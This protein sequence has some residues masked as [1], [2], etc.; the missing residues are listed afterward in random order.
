MSDSAV[1]L[2]RVFALPENGAGD[3]SPDRWNTFQATLSREVKTIKWPA[4]MPDVAE[5]IG[6][7][8]DVKLP[9][10]FL[11]SWKRTVELRRLLSESRT[12]PE[13]TKYF[14]LADHTIR[15][16]HHPYIEVKIRNVPVK[17]IE[18]TVSLACKLK[19]FVLRIKAGEIEEIRTGRCE[20]EGK[21]EF[22]GL[23]IAEKKLA[24]ID[25]PGSIK[26]NV[27]PAPS[28]TKPATPQVSAV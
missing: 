9:D 20:V 28:P 18:F 19:G 25:L 12:T 26:L 1:S 22:A 17:K 11:V 3:T 23:T 6:E 16:E 5:K 4:A 14:E 10:L 15:S 2:R 13:A 8:F 21:V 7:L 24:P 27:P